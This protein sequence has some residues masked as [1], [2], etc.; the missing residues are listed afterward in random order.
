MSEAERAREAL[1]GKY[2]GTVEAYVDG[3]ITGAI[4]A[5]EDRVLAAKRFK[6]MLGDE[7]YEWRPEQADFVIGLIESTFHHRQGEEPDGTPLMGKPLKLQPWQKFCVYGMLGFFHA[8]TRIRVV[9]E[10]LIFIPRKNGKTLFLAALSWAMAVLERKSGA[11]VYVIGAALRQAK[12]TF[13]SWKQ[14]TEQSLYNGPEDAKAHGWRILDNSFDHSLECANFAGGSIK[15]VALAANPDKQDSLNANIIIADELHAYKRPTQYNVLKEAVKA[16]TNKL[17][18]GITTAGDD[19][20]GFCAQ[21]VSYCR[22]VLRGTVED[23]Q[24]FIFL[25]SADPEE[26]G[27]IDYTNPLTHE[28]AN[29]SYGVTIRPQDILDDAM[30][31]QN[32]PQQRKDFLAKSL[33]VFTSS[34]KSWFDIQE[35]RQSDL[36]AGEALG[37]DP[38]W[39]VER[40]LKR[41]QALGVTW[42]GGADLSK[43]YDLT[44]AALHGQWHGIDIVIPH[45]WFP[46]TQATAKANE[47]SIPLFGWKDEG[48]LD[49]VNAPVNDH[50]RVVAW[51]KE[52][53]Q[54]GFRIKQV[55]HDRKFCREYFIG[56]KR[57]GFSI[58]D[59]PQY[60]YKKSEGFRHIE[61]QVKDRKFY[62]CGSDA[63]EYCVSNVRAIEK[64]DDMIQYEKIM[65]NHRIDIFDAD[66]FAVVRML[67]NMEKS[68]SAA[69]WLE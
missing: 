20:T 69:R 31:A 32:D 64:T 11:K 57:A 61:K 12:E 59:Q 28:K 54:K 6:R 60:F 27:S 2:A 5:N 65:P 7:R 58:V 17:V 4:V 36:T 63:Y 25:C 66:V 67:E 35:F 42:Y 33:N 47:D 9:H 34:M 53:R 18:C 13:D 21:R 37:I 51:F 16:Y 10:A 22:K 40:K 48:W 49:L 8:G 56:M 29:P 26:D 1:P 39:P 50:D 68:Q 62:Y 15:L 30:Q 52:M 24:Y 46:V 38:E 44:A 41:L 43:L 45:A 55:G 23:E 3:L 19:G 14:N